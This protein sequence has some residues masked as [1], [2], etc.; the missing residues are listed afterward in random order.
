[1]TEYHH[2]EERDLRIRTNLSLRDLIGYGTMLVIAGVMWGTL[3][4]RVSA[5]ERELASLEL[6]IS[7]IT[8]TVDALE[9]MSKDR[10]FDNSRRLDRIEI[11]LKHHK[12]K[13]KH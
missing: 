4:F 10:Y 8:D 13:E 5:I 2:D 3:S 6:Q 11:E 12:E 7:E 1:M 9:D